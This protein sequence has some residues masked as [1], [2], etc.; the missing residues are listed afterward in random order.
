MKLKLPNGVKIDLDENIN[1]DKKMVIVEDLVKQW[2][3]VIILNW[4]SNNIIFF[5]D[6]LANYIVWH[7][8]ENKKNTQDKDILS[9]RKVE[10]MSG[11]RKCKSTPFSALSQPQHETLFGERGNS[12]ES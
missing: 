10:E 11:K 3:D 9:V 8:D 4:N 6:G 5:L 2:N 7:K 12:N 1:I